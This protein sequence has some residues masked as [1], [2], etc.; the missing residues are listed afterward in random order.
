M[1]HRPDG[2]RGCRG[3]VGVCGQGEGWAGRGVLWL[4]HGHLVSPISAFLPW[5]CPGE[6]LPPV[7][8]AAVHTR[9]GL[10]QTQLLPECHGHLGDGVLEPVRPQPALPALPAAGLCGC[11]GTLAKYQ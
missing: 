4:L 10:N 11:V 3:W 6:L 1:T 9:L 7:L 5:F 2:G 8:G